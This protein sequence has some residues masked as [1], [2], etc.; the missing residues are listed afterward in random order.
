MELDMSG[1][2]RTKYLRLTYAPMVGSVSAP[3]VTLRSRSAR[4][5][6]PRRKPRNVPRVTAVFGTAAL[7]LNGLVARQYKPAR[8]RL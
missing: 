2:P 6:G 7:E 4:S 1:P 8:L 3:P 5:I